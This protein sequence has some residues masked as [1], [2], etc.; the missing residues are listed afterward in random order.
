MADKRILQE[1]VVKFGISGMDEVLDAQKKVRDNA[2]KSHKVAEEQLK[3][4]KSQLETMKKVADESEEWTKKIETQNDAIAKQTAFVTKMEKAARKEA[5]AFEDMQKDGNVL[6]SIIEKI[7]SGVAVSEKRLKAAINSLTKGSASIDPSKVADDAERK[8]LEAHKAGIDNLRKGLEAWLTTLHS[9]ITSLTEPVKLADQSISELTDRVKNYEQ[10]GRRLADTQ[11]NSAQV[12][13]KMGEEATKYKLRIAVLDGSLQKLNESMSREQVEKNMNFWKQMSQYSGASAKQVEVFT[14][15]YKEAKA[16]L[17]QKSVDMLSPLSVQ[18]HTPEEVQKSIDYLQKY[19]KEAR[20]S[21]RDQKK[22]N[23][24]IEVGTRYLKTFGDEAKYKSGTDMFARM[25]VELKSIDKLTKEGITDQ[26][27]YW[28]TVRSKAQE[29]SVEMEKAT[30]SLKALNEETQRRESERVRAEGEGLVDK[31]QLGSFSGNI[32]EIEDAIQKIQAYKKELNTSTEGAAITE[33]NDALTKLN[34]TLDQTK[35]DVTNGKTAFY[36]FYGSAVVGVDEVMKQ[37]PRPGEALRKTKE[38]LEAFKKSLRDK[39][40]NEIW[41]E[42][43]IDSLQK[44]DTMLT[45]IDRKQKSAAVSEIGWLK[46]D[47][48]NLR[49]RSLNELK[50][51]YEALKNEI[52]SLPPEQQEYN[53]KAMQMVQI[54]KRIKQLNKTLG[55]HKSSLENAASRLKNY[56]LIYFGWRQLMGVMRKVVDNTIELSDQMTNVRKVT[57]LTNLEIERMTKDLQAI[58]TRTANQQLME[59]AE[60]AGKLGIATRQGADGIVE[61]V[62]A[63]QEIV[64]TLGDIGGAEAITE[65]L[66]VNDVVNKNATSIEVDLGKIGSAILNIGNNSKA[67]YADITEFTKRLGA[68]GSAIGLSM[69]EIMGLG[70]A[71]SSLGE[72]MERS[73]TASQRV[74]L[75]I[76]TR[77]KEV[78]EALNISYAQMDQL[79]KSGDVMG[80]FIMAL[81]ALNE[82][83]VGAMEGFFKAIGGRNNQQARA[84]IALLSQHI[85]TLQYEVSLAKEGFRDGT[86]VT[87][88]FEK[89]NNN[90]AGVMAQVQNELYEM[91]TTI[92]GSNGVLLDAAKALLNFVKWLNSSAGAMTALGGVLAY[93]VAQLGAFVVSIPKVSMLLKLLGLQIKTTAIALKDLATIIVMLPLKLLG[94]E[95]ASK[96]ATAALNSLKAAGA[97]TWITALI[98][99]IGM[100]IGYLIE[101]GMKAKEAAKAMGEMKQKTEEEM[102]ALERLISSLRRVWNSQKE[103]QKGIDEFNKKFGAYYGHILSETASLNDLAIAYKAV[104]KA[105]LEKNAAELEAKAESHGMEV[106]REEREVA[107]GRIKTVIDRFA[108]RLKVGTTLKPEEAESLQS[109]L[110]QT[111]LNY[112]GDESIQNKSVENS[113]RFLEYKFRDDSRLQVIHKGNKENKRYN[114]LQDKAGNSE[115]NLLRALEDYSK[116]VVKGVETQ[117]RDIREANNLRGMAAEKA[118]QQAD[119]IYNQLTNPDRELT[120]QERYDLGNEYVRLQGEYGKKQP[121]IGQQMQQNKQTTGFDWLPKRDASNAW[122]LPAFQTPGVYDSTGKPLQDSWQTTSSGQDRTDEVKEI[123]SEVAKI[124]QPWGKTS[125]NWS[126]Q[127]GGDLAAVIKFFDDFEKNAKQGQVFSQTSAYH[128]PTGV[129]V[130]QDIDSWSKDKIVQWAHSNW[131]EARRIQKQLNMDN[132][133]GNFIDPKDKSSRSREKSEIKEEMDATLKKL[134]EYYERRNMLAEKYLNEGQISEEEYNRYMFANEQE[135]LMERQNLRKKWL[136]NDHDFMTQGVKDLMKDVDF[137]KVSAFLKGMGDDMVDGIK[138]NIAKDE[139]E[140]EK[141]IRA[142]REKVMKVLLDERPIAKV[143]EAFTKDLAELG[144]LFGD[145]DEAVLHVGEDTQKMMMERMSF[146]MQEA[147]KGYALTAERLVKDA[148]KQGNPLIETWVNNLSPEALSALVLKTQGFYDEYEDAV[149]KMMKRMEKR[150]EFERNHMGEDGIT[151]NLRWDRQRKELERKHGTQAVAESWGMTGNDM[152][153][154]LSSER[155]QVDLLQKELDIKL[156]QYNLDRKRYA[157]ELAAIEQK[158]RASKGLAEIT[159]NDPERQAESARHAEEATRLFQEAEA[160]KEASI[161]AE[162]EAWVGVQEAQRNATQAQFEL[163]S[164]TIEQVRPYYDTLNSFAEDFGSN[165]FGTKEDREQAARDMLAGLVKNTGRMLTQWLV[166]LSTKQMF[167]KME[168]LNEQAKQTQLLAIKRAAWAEELLALGQTAQAEE[169]VKSAQNLTD[170]ASA[171]AKEASK[172]GWLGWAIGA[173]LSL[174]MTMV[175]S[176]LSSKAKGAISAATG[177]SGAGKLAT[178][179]LTYAQGR[180]P[181]YADGAFATDSNGRTQGQLMSVRGNDGNTYM[182][183][184]QPNLKTGVVNSP[185]LG[186]VGEK[187]AEVII[188]HQTYEGLKRYDPE[189]LQRIYAMKA[190]GMR[191]I[192]FSRT[193]RMGNEVLLNRSGVRTYADGYGMD[194]LG[195]SDGLSDMENPTIAQMSQTLTELTAVLATIKADGIDAHMEYFGKGGAHETSK[196]GNKF[197]KRVGLGTAVLIMSLFFASCSASKPSLVEIVKTDTVHIYHTDTLHSVHNDTIRETVVRTLRDSVIKTITIKEVVNE[198]GDVIHSEKETTTDSF[199]DAETQ[200]QIIQHTVDSLLQVKMDS[201]YHFIDVNKMV[202]IEKT[203]PWYKRIWQRITDNFT[204]IGFAAVLIFILWL[205]NKLKPK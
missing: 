52:S 197:L 93:V 26:K 48:L 99:A 71:F 70:G 145:A 178:G 144:V 41:H 154:V 29:G 110:E 59:M 177:A 120:P 83:G 44:I 168:V 79:I 57:G 82:Q 136:D 115:M 16:M 12:F 183:K 123:V 139:N 187:G 8:T 77:T 116:A 86:L 66:K 96:R 92:E 169:A 121:A 184:Y 9:G 54:D 130:P 155:T 165:I 141:N 124:V 2:Q 162:Q 186:I 10:N 95:A 160:L 203:E 18:Y 23:Y 182:A 49:G 112:W 80:A 102:Y 56:V 55:E 72:S 104:A 133:N 175:F 24:A 191:S 43:Y 15:R 60:Q 181:T 14:E 75:G 194:K 158:A 166:Y 125:V 205:I 167:D 137:K 1:R 114:I 126:E 97:T 61:F 132:D 101:V 156:E 67:T 189:T 62:K 138:L 153:G 105:I 30:E 151:P 192:D 90:L 32:R 78:S 50:K 98:T 122:M 103:R 150:I 37:L 149:R 5:K 129:T 193:A 128:V 47:N 161:R 118:R 147:K 172:A 146:L 190:Y 134:E 198:Q 22:L 87:Q 63:G 199:H 196:K 107:S 40:G 195:A 3:L 180:Y 127:Y 135:H 33:A 42:D 106:S 38:D 179:M 11:E 64:N 200:S 176:A 39:P 94:V 91:T 188:D 163:M 157:E 19:Q 81:K 201:L 35:Q 152:A 34:D 174:L 142:S 58:D 6:K 113:L 131:E 148:K 100:L 25:S 65:L 173:G 76:V 17:T 119:K 159:A 164:Q 53:E 204:A 108:P 88:E 51:A 36:E 46:E 202:V 69:E 73:S 21:E 117:Q 170:A 27:K 28:E 74:L 140:V 143:A 20:L 7:E 109:E 171:Q 85:D 111:L 31:V 89:A 68:T 4:M 185:H 45:A 84:A 13:A